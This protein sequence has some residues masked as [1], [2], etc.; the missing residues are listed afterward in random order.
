MN[1][2]PGNLMYAGQA[3]ATPG[4]GGFAVFDSYSSGYQALLNQLNLYAN[5]TCA[6]CAGVPQTISGTFQIYA[7]AGSGGNN[8]TLY[9]Q[10]V[11]NS[12][13]VDPNTPLSSVLAGSAS[14]SPSPSLD[15]SSIGLPDLSSISS[16]DPTTLLI[17]G[18]AVV[19]LAWM[20]LR[21]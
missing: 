9:A 2:N 1:N 20:V 18:L 17:G 12:L 16:I 6:A 3:G 4:P 14:P 11:A 7:P 21:A 10:N 8:P 15:L 13:G 5:G 19:F